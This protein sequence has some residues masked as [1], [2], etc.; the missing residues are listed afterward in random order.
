MAQYNFNL[1]PDL[2]NAGTEGSMD[3]S[4]VDGV[5][6]QRT[7]V[8]LVVNGSNRK[9]VVLTDGEVFDDSVTSL[10]SYDNVSAVSED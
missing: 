3:T 9:V 2:V 10:A 4:V 6:A 7:G 8:M 5:S 1:T